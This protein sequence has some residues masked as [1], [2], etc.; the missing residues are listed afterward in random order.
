VY[1]TCVAVKITPGICG[2]TGEVPAGT[3]WIDK[4]VFVVAQIISM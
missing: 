4:S 1:I 2:E 3:V